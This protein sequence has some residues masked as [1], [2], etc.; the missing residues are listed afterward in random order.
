[1]YP[2]V[3]QVT[4]DR[5]TADVDYFR[6]AQLGG[7]WLDDYGIATQRLAGARSANDTFVHEANAQWVEFILTTLPSAG[8]IT[9]DIRRQDANNK[10]QL[11]VT[12]AGAFNLNEVVAGTPTTRATIASN[13][14]ADRM[15]CVF[16]GARARIMRSRAGAISSSTMYT[17]V[18]TFTT[19]TEGEVISLGT[20]GAISDLITW[21]RVLS[22]SA[23]AWVQAL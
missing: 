12:S 18:S 13:Q 2:S 15:M 5:H 7:P 20:D 17:S 23:L 9:I 16:D 8:S 4:S 10:W 22:G 11:E 21:P 6:V 3:G 19:E 1:M 14:A